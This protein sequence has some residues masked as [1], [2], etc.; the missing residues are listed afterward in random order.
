[1]EGLVS[2][3]DADVGVDPISGRSYVGVESGH[4]GPAA[5]HPPGHHTHHLEAAICHGAHQRA[6]AI[7]LRDTDDNS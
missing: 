1:M 7:T 4:L 6:A 5:V 2:E 3:V